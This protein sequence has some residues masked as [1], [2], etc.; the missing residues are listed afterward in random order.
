MMKFNLA[1]S[2]LLF[3]LAAGLTGAAH[4]AEQ[5][6]PSLAPGRCADIGR[7][8]DAVATHLHD[9]SAHRVSQA[10]APAG[11][12]TL[13]RELDAHIEALQANLPATGTQRAQ[14]SLLLSDMRDAAS[15]MRSAERLDARAIA[16]QRIERDGRLYESVVRSLGCSAT[17]PTPL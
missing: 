16:A 14:A 6:P 4:A 17:R 13:A 9:A 1:T 3:A 2:S 5:T 8:I 11:Y 7:D 12:E 15:L 10:M